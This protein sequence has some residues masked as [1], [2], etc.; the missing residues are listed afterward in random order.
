MAVLV[1]QEQLQLRTLIEKRDLPGV[2]SA[3]AQCAWG[4][5]SPRSLILGVRKRVEKVDPADRVLPCQSDSYLSH[6][7]LQPHFS[8]GGRGLSVLV[9]Q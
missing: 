2:G 8:T 7:Y 6:V 1:V 9:S 4:Q 5:V 3:Q